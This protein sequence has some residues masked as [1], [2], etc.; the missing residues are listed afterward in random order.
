MT[1]PCEKIVV[2]KNNKSPGG[3]SKRRTMERKTLRYRTLVKSRRK[4]ESFSESR[5]REWGRVFP[6]P[7]R[8]GQKSSG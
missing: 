4:V 5:E 1:C 8:L 2:A 6:G 7:R 3:N